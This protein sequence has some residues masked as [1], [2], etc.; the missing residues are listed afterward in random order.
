MAQLGVGKAER[1][2]G[3]PWAPEGKRGN[4]CRKLAGEAVGRVLT[5]LATQCLVQ[6]GNSILDFFFLIV[7]TSSFQNFS[8][9]GK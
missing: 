9:N 8:E 2:P 3:R 5:S 4:P 1:T 6:D 7:K